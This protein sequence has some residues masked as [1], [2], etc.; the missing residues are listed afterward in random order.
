MDQQ[1]AENV[2]ALSRLWRAAYAP[3]DGQTSSAYSSQPVQ[4]LYI[5]CYVTVNNPVLSYLLSRL[6]PQDL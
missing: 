1:Q 3:G 5:S 4:Y 2:P 6:L